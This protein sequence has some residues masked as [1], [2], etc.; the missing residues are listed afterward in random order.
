M[1]KKRQL[2]VPVNRQTFLRGMAGAA[3]AGGSGNWRIAGF[4]ARGAVPARSAGFDDGQRAVV[5]IDLS[6]TTGKRVQPW[7]Y[8]Y[9]S[10][11]L[12]DRDFRLAAN[13][14]AEKS[15]EKLSPA[16]VRLNTPVQSIIQTVFARGASRP[17]WAPLS[18]WVRHRADYLGKHGRLVFGIGPGGDDTS[19]PPATWAEYARATAMHFRHIGQEIT[20]W[21]VGNECD[22]MGAVAYSRY[23]NKIADALHS[24]N[25]SN[26]VG[27]PV[28]SWWNGIDLPAFVRHSGSKIGFIDFHSYQVKETDSVRTAYEKAVTFA[29]VTSARRAIAGTV[30]ASLPIGLLEYNMN[31]DRQSNGSHGLAAQG[32]IVGAVY[33]ALLLTQAFT[34]DT[35]FTMGGMWDLIANSN[36]GAIANAQDDTRYGA[37]DEQGWYLRQ[38]A[39]IMPGQQVHGT[40]TAPG[41]QV[42]ATRTGPHFSIQLVNYY[43]RTAQSVA[44]T[45]KGTMPK[46][47]ISRWELSARHP[48]GRLSTIPG[49]ARVSVPPQ[50]IVILHGRR[51][52]TN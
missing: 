13:E 3:I 19:I 24:V 11:A 10:G 23:F 40:S 12:L 29:D 35:R 34:S 17:D 46:S 15:A 49:L 51:D 22:A 33:A 37:I 36:F 45:I 7:L 50:S 48:K 44:I 43:L 47:H 30:A 38:A 2:A 1:D 25:P 32:T 9:A 21:E 31:A 52:D 4:S 28:S 16:L 41:L 14:A 18:D 5:M 26:L 20:Y 39:K 6:R 27:G 8:G 42:L